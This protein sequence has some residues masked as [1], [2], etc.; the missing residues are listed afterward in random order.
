MGVMNKMRESTAAILWILVIAFG[1]I[2]VFTD[3]GAMDVIG[4]SNALNVATVDGEPIEREQFQNLLNNYIQ[5]AQQNGQEVTQAMRDQYSDL[6]FNALIERKLREREMK[7][8]GIQVTDQEVIDMVFGASPDPIILQSFSDG[9]GG[10]NRTALKNF[11]ENAER[12]PQVLQIQDYLREKRA[13]EKLDKLLEATVRISDA[14]VVDEYLRRNQTYSAE[15]IALRYAD[16]QDKSVTISDAELRSYYNENKEEFKRKKSYSFLFASKQTT[17]TSA[18][19]ARVRNELGTLRESF[20]NAKD[21]RS[22]FTQNNSMAPLDSTYRDKSQF[23]PVLA[24]MLF[25]NP[26]VGTVVGPVAD[27]GAFHLVKIL[28]VKSDPAYTARASHI[29]VEQEAKAKELMT[30]LQA[31]GDFATLAKANSKD[32]GSGQNGGDLGEAPTANYVPE[33]RKAV[34][35]APLNQLVGPVKTQFGYHIIKVATRT[36][37]TSSKIQVANFMRPIDVGAE[38]VDRIRKS[39]EDFQYFATEAND[40]R[41]EAKKQK[42]QVQNTSVEEGANT[43]PL[44]G[45][46]RA[47]MNFLAKA[48]PNQISDV[49]ELDDKMV[50]V[51]LLESKPEGYKSVEELKTVLEPR[52]RNEKK[53]NILEERFRTAMTK[54]GFGNGLAQAL[55][56]NVNTAT[57]LTYNNA[58]IQTLGREAKF[59]G[60]LSALKPGQSSGIIVGENGVYVVKLTSKGNF[61]ASTMKPDEKA[62]IVQTLR[63]QGLQQ[64]KTRWMEQLREKAE[65]ED[66]RSNFNL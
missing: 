31:G 3:S 57:D 6:V 4:R 18:D 36:A 53:K 41:T 20:A 51:Q 30:Q 54:N 25:A 47:I 11:W 40:F 1:G 5:Q 52:A 43:I 64:V 32:P 63:Q 38:A 65:I 24:N 39:M 50:V 56:T 22:F 10:I 33:F 7:K 19:S 9:K 13:Q 12:R 17:A 37:T 46:S 29:L 8:L 59:V 27:A 21:Y 42:L 44:L 28:G 35:T 15:Y 48:K 58:L 66:F 34:E 26:T 2:W 23:G 16:I 61:N 49:V 45:P 55:K 60:A 14:D 62:E